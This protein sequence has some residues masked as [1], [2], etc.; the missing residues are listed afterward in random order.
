MSA[1]VMAKSSPAL[2]SEAVFLKLLPVVTPPYVILKTTESLLYRTLTYFKA[3]D[4][5]FSVL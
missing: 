1:A 2:W 3:D 4:P 5:S